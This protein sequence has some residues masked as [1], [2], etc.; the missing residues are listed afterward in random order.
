MVSRLPAPAPAVGRPHTFATNAVAASQ[1]CAWPWHSSRASRARRGCHALARPGSIWRGAPARRSPT[2]QRAGS[3]GRAG[4]GRAHVGKD[5]APAQRGLRKVAWEVLLVLVR[6][7]DVVDSNAVDIR[8]ATPLKR[9]RSH[10][11]YYLGRGVLRQ[12]S[13]V[14][15]AD[16]IRRLG[17]RKDYLTYAEL[18]GR[19]EHVVRAHRVDEVGLVV[20]PEQYARDGC[21]M[22]DGVKARLSTAR[23]AVPEVTAIV[24]L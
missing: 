6:L 19:L 23:A 17:G 18:E 5:V 3:D 1:A 12:T 16:S 22:D 7:D 24:K 10:L 20:R 13:R 11:I 2:R 15:E 21:K 4:Q 8:A 14:G 9:A